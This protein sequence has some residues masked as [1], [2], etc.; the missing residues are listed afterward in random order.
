[1]K[2]ISLNARGLEAKCPEVQRTGEQRHR[3]LDA[4]GS[5][6]SLQPEDS[7]AAAPKSPR[8]SKH[9]SQSSRASRAAISSGNSVFNAAKQGSAKL[10]TGALTSVAHTGVSRR[11]S[12][13]ARGSNTVMSQEVENA[14]PNRRSK[15]PEPQAPTKPPRVCLVCPAALSSRDDAR[16]VAGQSSEKLGKVAGL[17]HLGSPRQQTHETRSPRAVSQD[18]TGRSSRRRSLCKKMSSEDLGSAVKEAMLC[19]EPCTLAK[20]PRVSL[21]TSPSRISVS[22]EKS[23]ERMNKASPRSPRTSLRSPKVGQ[24]IRTAPPPNIA[25]SKQ[26]STQQRMCRKTSATDLKAPAARTKCTESK[27]GSKDRSQNINSQAVAIN[28]SRRRSFAHGGC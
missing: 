28:S 12:L 5:R 6:C 18:V 25:S 27:Q 17:A 15:S 21:T 26:C 20:P 4:V 16:N 2:S 3:R 11:Q 1:M 23:A 10:E 9:G 13:P 8:L 14:C 19:E 7:A 22:D 24:P